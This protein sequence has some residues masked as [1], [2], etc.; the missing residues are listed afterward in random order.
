MKTESGGILTGEFISSHRP[1]VIQ[2]AMILSKIFNDIDKIEFASLRMIPFI[3]TMDN[4]LAH[5]LQE[6]END[7]IPILNAYARGKAKY[8]DITA[9]DFIAGPITALVRS[10][11][12]DKI[13]DKAARETLVMNLAD[14]KE[15]KA[16]LDNLM[17]HVHFN[18]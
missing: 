1:S 12:K 2:Q 18:N 3:D 9:T 7:M 13:P 17:K 16:V 5:K 6:K 15:T 10:A 4:Y 14:V 8:R 11:L